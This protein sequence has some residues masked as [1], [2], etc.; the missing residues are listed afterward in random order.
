MIRGPEEFASELSGNLRLDAL[1][2]AGDA[3]GTLLRTIGGDLTAIKALSHVT[4]SAP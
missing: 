2:G 1:E 3:T 4:T